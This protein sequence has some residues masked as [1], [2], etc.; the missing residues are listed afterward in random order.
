MKKRILGILLCALLLAVLPLSAVAASAPAQST[1]R[2]QQDYTISASTVNSYL[3]DNGAGFTRVEWINDHV[4]V[5]DYSYDFK[6]A[7]G[8]TIAPELPVWGGFFAGEDYNFL[9]FGQKN[10]EDSNTQ[11]VIRIVKYDKAWKRLGSASLNGA[12]TNIPFHAASLRCAEYNG[13][14][15]IR[16]G[17]RMFKSADGLNHQANMTMAVRQSDMSITDSY[18][19][20]MNANYGYVS[21]SF[22][23][24]ILVDADGHLVSLDHGDAYPRSF[25]LMRYYA[26]ASTGIFRGGDWNPWC[27]ITNLETF[28]G[29]IGDN[30]TG[31]SLGG[32][33]E[34]ANGYIAAYNYNPDGQSASYRHVVLQYIP[35]NGG[36]GSRHIFSDLPFGTTPML[37]STGLDGGYVL[38]NSKDG[39]AVSD[40]LYWLTYDAGGRVGNYKTAKASLSDCQPIA[41][42]GGIVWYVTNSSAPTFYVLND[43]G[44][45]SYAVGGTAAST[46][47]AG[48]PAKTR[49]NDVPAWAY[50]DVEYVVNK[51]LFNGTDANRFTPNENI[52][53]AQL[54]VVLARYAGQNTEAAGGELWYQKG[55][56]WAMQNGIIA[57]ANPNRQLTREEFV[58][59]MYN[60]A[61]NVVGNDLSADD[62]ALAGFTDTAKLSA[63][64][65]EAMK[66]AVSVGLVSGTTNT[67]LSPDALLNR[68]QVAVVLS[69]YDQM[70]ASE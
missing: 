16:T 14:L 66:W 4:V 37:A 12:N 10:P 5:E 65:A 23:Q 36:S 64:S 56:D 33:K 3:Y 18:Y 61:K 70:P 45:T 68:V 7:S 15:Y 2:N 34:T 44:L 31:A 13:Y 62:D 59:M 20:V 32:L 50:N 67:T 57:A 29:Q 9:I 42:N 11:E 40:T 52:T 51:G 17:H 19:E 53:Q 22:N 41:Y 58:I 55:L 49:F 1:N 24:F 26:D 63:A 21:H 8:R 69:R 60:Y 35:K 30:Y 39:Y 27:S 43:G 54:A 25:V 6:Y 47:S 48:N 28:E 38:W 46:G